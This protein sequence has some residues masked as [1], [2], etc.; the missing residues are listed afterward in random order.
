MREAAFPSPFHL[1][2]SPYS[3]FFLN[4]ALASQL[5]NRGFVVAEFRQNLLGMLAQRW[6]AAA[7]RARRLREPHRDARDR[8]WTRQAWILNAAE[9]TH[10]RRLRVIERLLGCQH[11]RR[12]NVFTAENLERLVGGS[13]A[14]PALHPR[15]DERAVVAARDVVLEARVFEPDGLPHEPCPTAIERIA[16]HLADD[17]AVLGPEKID[18]RRG[19][20]AIAGGHA[21]GIDHAL[22]DEQSVGIGERGRQERALHLLAAPAL[23]PRHQ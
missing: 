2:A 22:L 12:R 7:E 21:V 18:R 8:G 15:A 9:E 19:L 5:G 17:P 10:C 11:G 16:H 20:A 3:L 13:F 1:P 4:D 14:A 6:R 23:A